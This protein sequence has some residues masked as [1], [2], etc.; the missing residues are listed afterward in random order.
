MGGGLFW[1]QNF[2][3][4]I[5]SLGGNKILG[6]I[7]SKDFQTLDNFSSKVANL[8]KIFGEKYEIEKIFPQNRHFLLKF[9]DFLQY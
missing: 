6:E 5:E 3:L 2:F 1:G 8:L 7:F 9:N 4:K